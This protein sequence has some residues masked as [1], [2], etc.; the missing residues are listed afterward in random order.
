MSLT[1]T[2][3]LRVPGVLKAVQRL[4]ERQARNNRRDL[5]KGRSKEHNRIAAA[6]AENAEARRLAGERVAEAQIGAKKK[7]Y[8]K[9][10]IIGAG[11]VGL[12]LALLLCRSYYPKGK[13]HVLQNQIA[14]GFFDGKKKKRS[15]SSGDTN[16][17]GK[18][19]SG[20]AKADEDAIASKQKNP[21]DERT[22]VEDLENLLHITPN[23]IQ[24]GTAD[25][26][27]SGMGRSRGFSVSVSPSKFA[28][29][30]YGSNP[31]SNS[32]LKIHIYEK[33]PLKSHA[34]RNIL[35]ALS[36]QTE[37]LLYRNM[38]KAT[39]A[40][41]PCAPLADLE[42]SLRQE[43]EK[44]WWP[45]VKFH[46]DSAVD[47]DEKVFSKLQTKCEESWYDHKVVE[48]VG[49]QL[50]VEKDE[51]EFLMFDD[52]AV[53][54]TAE[55]LEQTTLP[56][57]SSAKAKLLAN[58]AR[59]PAFGAGRA[60]CGSTG[61][62]ALNALR[63][64]NSASLV[65]S[66]AESISRGFEIDGNTF[67]AA[68][69]CSGKSAVS[70]LHKKMNITKATILSYR[71]KG[72]VVPKELKEKLKAEQAAAAGGA[73]GVE[74][75]EQSSI[76]EFRSI[77]DR[78]YNNPLLRSE[79]II[80]RELGTY[81]WVWLLRYEKPI[82]KRR[83]PAAGKAKDSK[84]AD[85]GGGGGN[86]PTNGSRKANKASGGQKSGLVDAD[87]MCD[88]QQHQATKRPTKAEQE[89]QE[90]E[91]PDGDQEKQ[92]DA[93]AASAIDELKEHL[94]ATAQPTPVKQFSTF[95]EMT[96]N[97]DNLDDPDTLF[98]AL[99]GSIDYEKAF[100]ISVNVTE[101]NHWG[102]RL[103]PRRDRDVS[104]NRMQAA[105]SP[106]RGTAGGG[107]MGGEQSQRKNSPSPSAK[108]GSP[109]PK[110]SGSVSPPGGARGRGGGAGVVQGMIGGASSVLNSGVLPDVV[111]A[112]P[113]GGRAKAK[114]E[115][116]TEQKNDTV[117][118]FAGDAL[119]GKPFYLGT[120]LQFHLHDMNFLV[121]NVN[122]T[123]GSALSAKDF[124][125][126]ES[127]MRD[128]IQGFLTQKNNSI[129]KPVGGGGSS[130]SGKAKN[131]DGTPAKTPRAGA[132]AASGGASEQDGRKER[133]S[134]PGVVSIPK[135]SMLAVGADGKVTEESCA[136]EEECAEETTSC[137][138][139]PP[140]NKAEASTH[141]AA[142]VLEQAEVE[143][144]T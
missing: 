10:A 51:N 80:I 9:I 143:I 64:N 128:T 89:E 32:L 98:A 125:A 54:K 90:N 29:K 63:A 14:A 122:W 56:S 136:A 15:K 24:Q 110:R 130:P 127:R 117:I 37:S 6:F 82:V 12:W 47:L 66:D 3:T 1:S 55:L 73:E 99:E 22:V 119:C 115:S 4:K 107:G 19:Q 60:G 81:G 129:A 96:S 71:K 133:E 86:S 43:L 95:A 70:H 142:I 53:E 118:C 121:S 97:V 38:S 39:H 74:K 61:S 68:F 123:K 30:T 108:S 21:E 112:L 40:W 83:M 113:R 45:C 35:L 109:S 92:E 88:E 8:T 25:N 46:W 101:A 58:G 42:K 57:F 44:F 69:I 85:A 76:S 114:E 34:T 111:V 20:P 49:N 33:R 105:P 78:K 132:V 31:E 65:D 23:T 26:E 79:N 134:T 141:L 135:V 28:A 50:Q 5:G 139:A 131:A 120:T 59:N 87:A 52:D 77:Q 138:I 104:P 67:D 72:A 84:Q 11:P 27:R 62:A 103:A 126:Y 36:T 48:N 16:L 93:S 94:E 140:A 7:A 91:D 75:Q 102:L 137:L 17:G 116:D 41:S 13:E 2:E 18:S 100:G 144:T 106:K 124:R